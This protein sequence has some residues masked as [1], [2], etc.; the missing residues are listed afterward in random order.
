MADIHSKPCVIRETLSVQGNNSFLAK[1]KADYL[2]LKIWIRK[3]KEKRRSRKGE[4][5]NGSIS[6]IE[7]LSLRA[8]SPHPPERKIPHKE[9]EE[10]LRAHL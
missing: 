3:K 7:I 6:S 9:H 8:S 5:R 4:R 2:L 10:E 1:R